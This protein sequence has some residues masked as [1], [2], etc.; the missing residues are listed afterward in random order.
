MFRCK[1]GK[2]YLFDNL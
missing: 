1:H 2:A